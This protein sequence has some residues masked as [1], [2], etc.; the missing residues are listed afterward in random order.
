VAEQLMNFKIDHSATFG[1]M[2]F[3]QCTPKLKFGSQVQEATP[4]G[5]P[6][7]DVE[8]VAAVRNN[9]GGLNNQVLKVG[10]TATKNPATDL[11]PFT[12]VTLADLEV[13]VMEK[14]KRDENGQQKII[15]AQTWLR[16][17]AI[18]PTAMQAAVA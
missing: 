3:M 13:G 11:E 4:D 2:V 17:S 1:G 7:W 12:P 10:I 16:A 15:G 8:V 9:F 18:R 5:T 14:T 6:K